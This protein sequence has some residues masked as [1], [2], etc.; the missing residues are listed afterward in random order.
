M[1][2]RLANHANFQPTTYDLFDKLQS[3][4]SR[5]QKALVAYWISNR[6]AQ[7]ISELNQQSLY[8]IGESD[9]RPVPRKMPIWNNDPY[10]FLI[11]ATQD[12]LSKFDL[13]R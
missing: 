5:W 4:L 3:V 13:M 12:D 11:A 8:D 10:G 9:C 1:H 6:R 7:I 2:K